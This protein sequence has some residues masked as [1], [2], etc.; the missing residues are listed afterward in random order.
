MRLHVNDK[1]RDTFYSEILDLVSSYEYG[2]A[3]VLKAAFEKAGRKLGS[4]EVD[5]LLL[6]LKINPTGNRCLKKPVTRWL[7]VIWL[8]AMRN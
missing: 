5:R 2:F 3:M 7:V 6:S 1:V 4:I 8:S